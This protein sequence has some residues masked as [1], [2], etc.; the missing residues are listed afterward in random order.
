MST[1]TMSRPINRLSVM[2]DYL[3][4]KEQTERT[5]RRHYSETL[6]E[7]YGIAADGTLNFDSGA[8]Y[9]RAEQAKLE[10][11]DTKTKLD[12]HNIKKTFTGATLQ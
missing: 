5:K 7:H 11:L 4:E 2:A 9:T 1:A 6:G 12:V 8:T 10:H 3:V